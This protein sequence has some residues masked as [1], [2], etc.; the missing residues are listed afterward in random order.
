MK[1]DVLR[2]A[3]V[4]EEGEGQKGQIN[5]CSKKINIHPLTIL[6]ELIH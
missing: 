5:V 3:R 1:E 4:R 2:E 6:F